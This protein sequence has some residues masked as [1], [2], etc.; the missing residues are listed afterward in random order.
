MISNDFNINQLKPIIKQYIKQ[1]SDYENII[2]IYNWIRAIITTGFSNQILLINGATFFDKT[3]L[4]Q[5]LIYYYLQLENNS[6]DKTN[7]QNHQMVSLDSIDSHEQYTSSLKKISFNELKTLFY[8][9]NKDQKNT[10]AKNREKITEIL[11]N[12][13]L[14]IEDIDDL[15]SYIR[16]EFKSFIE[17][18]TK[19]NLPLIL[20]SSNNFTNLK[21]KLGSDICEILDN[22]K[23]TTIHIM[24]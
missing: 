24:K 12:Q 19:E 18:R 13:I 9:D 16:K 5:Y 8:Y 14:F 7:N 11:K 15:N 20:T 10:L 23:V 4:C 1:T 17:E 22:S 21:K 6:K 3:V 2:T